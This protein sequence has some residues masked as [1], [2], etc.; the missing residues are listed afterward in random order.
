V[1]PDEEE[2]RLIKR[3][4]FAAAILRASHLI[5]LASV[6]MVLS[7]PFVYS[8]SGHN[9]P[10]IAALIVM[11]IFALSWQVLTVMLNPKRGSAWVMLLGYVAIVAVP[12]IASMAN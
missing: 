1:I 12:A 10:S 6:L 7:V 11:Y 4:R 9:K 5:F 3:T 2:L 8:M